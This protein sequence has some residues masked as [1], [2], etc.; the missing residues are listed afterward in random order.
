MIKQI[1]TILICFYFQKQ[2]CA[3]HIFEVTFNGG[4][5]YL[6]SSYSTSP[7]NDTRKFF[8]VPSFQGGLFY[9]WNLK[10]HFS[11]G[12][13]IIFQQ[14]N[15]KEK[16]KLFFNDAMGKIIGTLEYTNFTSLSYLGIPVHI[17]YSYKKLNLNI[18]IQSN[19]RL[20]AYTRNNQ[21]STY[22]GDTVTIESKKEKL[23][24]Y[25]RYNYGLRFGIQFHLTKRVSISSNYYYGL[26]NL[27]KD[28]NISKDIKRKVQQITIGL[29]YSIY[30]I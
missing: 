6:H 16:F 12:S 19:L 21:T 29:N 28:K 17:G 4:I 5:S 8:I 27:M 3:Q 30:K 25:D 20:S 10:N 13:E 9:N 18:G 11:I 7:V 24:A 23:I 2:I 26:N 15:G 1:I 14:I 22:N